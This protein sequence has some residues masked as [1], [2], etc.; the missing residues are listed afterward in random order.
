M[1]MDTN[2]EPAAP[3]IAAAL[4]STNDSTSSRA[5]RLAETLKIPPPVAVTPLLTALKNPKPN[6]R[7]NAVKTLGKLHAAATPA[8]PAL[9]ETLNDPD[10]ALRTAAK[11]TLM[12]IPD[13]V[14]AKLTNALAQSDS[15]GASSALLALE[16]MGERA[17][18]AVPVIL[19]L[20]EEQPEFGPY[21][22]NVLRSIAPELARDALMPSMIRVPTIFQY[23]AGAKGMHENQTPAVQSTPSEARSNQ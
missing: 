3:F 1:E 12:Q 21:Y 7:L 10:I 6:L 15:D 13:Y 11:Q 23:R 16:G 4:C 20:I 2:A 9:L 19:H 17:R 22:T 18:P 14:I 5:A 8:I